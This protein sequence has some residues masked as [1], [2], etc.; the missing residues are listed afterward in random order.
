M[1]AKKAQ[2][3]VEYI[4]LLSIVLLLALIVVSV[5]GLVPSFSEALGSDESNY[6][7]LQSLEVGITDYAV[8]QDQLWLKLKNNNAGVI[9]VRNVSIDLADCNLTS[10]QQ[11]IR[12]DGEFAAIVN[13]SSIDFSDYSYFEF[14]VDIIWYD[15]NSERSY[16]QS[17]ENIVI[18]GTVALGNYSS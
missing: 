6:L 15:V 12:P 4:V 3:T 7:Y 13:C 14:D 16:L 18:S 9:E 11:F 5:L 1:N 8:F 2:M 10:D 17:N